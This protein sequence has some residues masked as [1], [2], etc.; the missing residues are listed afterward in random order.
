MPL[1]FKGNITGTVTSPVY[2]LP[3]KIT[4]FTVAN[5]NAGSTT[6]DLT[7]TDGVENLSISPQSLLLSEGDMLEGCSQQIMEAGSQIKI[8][9]NASVD[10]F[11]TIE[12]MQPQ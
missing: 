2:N 8:V 12:N 11:F 9:S 3:F 5:K 10:Y 4:F 7:V 1:P 6:I